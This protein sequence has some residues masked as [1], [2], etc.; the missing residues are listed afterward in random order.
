[1]GGRGGA[2]NATPGQAADAAAND[3]ALD[4]VR[5]AIADTRTSN[6]QLVTLEHVR[7]RMS[8]LGISSRQEQDAELIRLARARKISL[9]PRVYQA[10]MTPGERA[11]ELIFGNERK[12]AVMMS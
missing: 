6:Q 5:Q 10:T 12:G 8:G 2:P 3:R 7:R 9:L 4:A 11:A 1:M